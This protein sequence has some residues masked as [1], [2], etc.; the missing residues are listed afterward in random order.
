MG[1]FKDSEENVESVSVVKSIV[2]GTG[3][4]NIKES[5]VKVESS[6][7]GNTTITANPAI[8]AG[9]EGQKLTIYGN[10]NTKTVTLNSGNGVLLV[11]AAA[12]ILGLNDN[13]KLKYINSL[14]VEE[15]RALV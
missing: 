11:G 3:I 4:I 2:A 8:E 6:T 15:S 1:I 14:W 9:V 7:A 10:D 5:N 13:I 12:I